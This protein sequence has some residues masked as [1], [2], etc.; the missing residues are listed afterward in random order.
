M[1]VNI[2]D[3]LKNTPLICAVLAWFIAQLI[4][5][6]IELCRYRRFD[7]TKF[8]SSGGMPSSHSS[9]VTSLTTSIAMIYGLDSV[10]FAI[11]AVVSLVVMYDAA[12]V[13]RETGKQAIVI[14]NLVDDLL[15]D[16]PD[17]FP[18]EL[19]ELVGHTPLQVFFGALL[20]IIV[21]IIYMLVQ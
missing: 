8:F 17:Y 16:K 6:I 15:D 13:R 4:K 1:N 20:G 18:K 7:Y 14:N 3:L 5:F 2:S 12:G 21:A 19:K 11:S 9:F 10:Y